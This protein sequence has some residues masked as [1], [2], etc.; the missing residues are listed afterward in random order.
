MEKSC[1]V[2]GAFDVC[3]LCRVGTI[4]LCK[5]PHRREL[6]AANHGNS[7]DKRKAAVQSLRDKVAGSD[8]RILVFAWYLQS[9]EY[10]ERDTWEAI[11]QILSAPRAAE[12]TMIALLYEVTVRDDTSSRYFRY[13]CTSDWGADC[14]SSCFSRK[15]EYT[16]FRKLLCDNA[17]ERVLAVLLNG[18]AKFDDFMCLS[19]GC[20]KSVQRYVALKETLTLLQRIGLVQSIRMI[21]H[22][23]EHDS[24]SVTLVTSRRQIDQVQGGLLSQLDMQGRVAHKCNTMR[25]I[26][27]VFDPT[28][29]FCWR[30][31]SAF[32]ILIARCSGCGGE[33]LLNSRTCS[34]APLPCN[35]V[36]DSDAIL[37]ALGAAI[38]SGEYL[39]D[40]VQVCAN[41][42]LDI[43]TNGRLMSTHARE[44]ACD[45]LSLLRML[46]LREF[47]DARA[48]SAPTRWLTLVRCIL[49]A[50][51]PK[52]CLAGA[53]QAPTRPPHR[54]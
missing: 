52:C 38:N 44:A 46:E 8:S 43:G 29:D 18:H 50:P 25:T 22:K 32:A 45:V 19:L 14:I 33:V 49:L 24:T 3:S 35:Y 37:Q 30:R 42:L 41:I 34:V 11:M 26:A 2:S 17:D 51:Y 21:V 9:S 36:L 13:D 47:R 12:W 5:H 10:Y 7:L 23:D 27:D 40:T 28:K 4:C 39:A 20:V 16:K 1:D 31:L 15:I 48:P 53:M 6:W 54:A